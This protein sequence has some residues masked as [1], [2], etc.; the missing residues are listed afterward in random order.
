MHVIMILI[1]QIKN[2]SLPYRVRY[3][4]KTEKVSYFVTPV[5]QPSV[6]CCV[7]FQIIVVD[8]SIKMHGFKNIVVK[9]SEM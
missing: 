8:P 9:K 1:G 5:T 7:Y 6:A 4:R 2:C 3:C